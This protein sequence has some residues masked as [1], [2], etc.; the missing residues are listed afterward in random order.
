M[1]VLRVGGHDR[2]ASTNRSFDHGDV[3]DVIVVGLAGQHAD[4]PCLL[5]AK[6]LDFAHRQQS[7]QA[8]LPGVAPPGFGENGGG[9]DGR[10][11]FGEEA[12]VE[13]PQAPVVAIAA[14]SAPVS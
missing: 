13:C 2:V 6:R 4:V 12:S 7:R 9:H 10:D 14:T 3:D 5:L 1:E 11:L 8:R